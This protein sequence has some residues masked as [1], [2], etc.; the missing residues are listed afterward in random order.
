MK[1]QSRNNKQHRSSGAPVST[2]TDPDFRLIKSD[3]AL[4]EQFLLNEQR[5]ILNLV[6]R[7]L[8]HPVTIHED[9]WSVALYSVSQAIDSYDEK[10]GSFWGYAAIVMKSRLTDLYRSEARHFPELTAGPEIFDGEADEESPEFSLQC[11][12]QSRLAHQ[13]DSSLRDEILALQGE[14][15]HFGISFF[16]L[17]ECSP[18]SQKT[19]LSCAQLVRAMFTPPPPLTNEMKRKKSLPIRELLQRVKASRKLIDR[20][21][22]YLIASSLILDGDYP[23]LASYL[24]YIKQDI[25]EKEEEYRHEACR[26]GTA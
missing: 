20:Y 9:E 10:K 11:E 14:L 22:R 8:Q 17:A 19:R 18:K 25:S 4:R 16:D 12:V 23:G 21:R 13:E 7:I 1:E 26:I 24:T 2:P 3:P 6:A 5:H 15:D